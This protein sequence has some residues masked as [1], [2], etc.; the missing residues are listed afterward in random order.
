MRRKVSLVLLLAAF[1]LAV[2]RADDKGEK[3]ELGEYLSSSD[4]LKAK[5]ATFG[6]D[7]ASQGTVL[8]LQ[9]VLDKDKTSLE[10]VEQRFTGTFLD[11][12]GYFVTG[13][14]LFAMDALKDREKETRSSGSLLCSDDKRGTFA[15][16]KGKLYPIHIVSHLTA[17]D[18]LPNMKGAEG[19]E[20]YNRLFAAKGLVIAKVGAFDKEGRASFDTTLKTPALETGLLK[21]SDTAAPYTMMNRPMRVFIPGY[22]PN[23]RF[24]VAT[25][26]LTTRQTAA[27]GFI[28]GPLPRASLE[29]ALESAP[30]DIAGTILKNWDSIGFDNLG[31]TLRDTLRGGP[32]LAPDGTIIGYAFSTD[33][34]KNEVVFLSPNV[35][36]DAFFTK[37]KPDSPLLSINVAGETYY[38]K[39]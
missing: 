31:L 38:L 30:K 29:K 37:T 12:N 17:E 33:E 8:L 13:Y 19:A 28:A 7:S 39:R 25:G 21:A 4:A 27:K 5:G 24:T 10:K 9:G 18:S 16:I 3:K 11:E 15:S 32:A 22:L 23:K 2:A 20:I 14:R 1:S 34:S 6:W 26:Y 35:M 36:L